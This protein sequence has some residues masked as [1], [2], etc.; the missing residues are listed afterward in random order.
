MLDANQLR[1]LR[2]FARRGTLAATADALGYTPS[3]VSQQL[4]SLERAA[5]TALTRRVGRKLILTPAGERLA[6][7]ADDVLSALE[8]AQ[9]A[10]RGADAR[11]AG[12]VRL[13]VFQSAALALLPLA[14]GNARRVAPEL[15]VQVTQ[16]EPAQALEDTWA[17]DFDLVVAEEYPHHSAPHYAGLVRDTL[18]ADAVRLATPLTHEGSTIGSC[19]A[20]P[21]VMEPHGAA[22]RHFAEQLCRVAGFEPDVR[23]VTADLQAHVALVRAGEAVALLPDLMLT[24]ADPALAMHSLPQAPTR[25]VFTAMRESSLADPAIRVVVTALREAAAHLGTAS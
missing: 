9:S 21:W 11:V 8:R 18:V 6:A 2:E 22:S 7:S 5:G 17:R 13:A 25:T 12:T 1:T 3:A 24:D 19:A 16:S 20:T 4:T 23:F 10:V 15:R 14:L